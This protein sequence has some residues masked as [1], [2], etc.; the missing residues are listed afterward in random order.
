MKNG[1]SR[2]AMSGPKP[3]LGKSFF[4]CCGDAGGRIHRSHFLLR[5]C[6]LV[7]RRKATDEETPSNNAV[8]SAQVDRENGKVLRPQERFRPRRVSRMFER[9]DQNGKVIGGQRRR[10]E[11]WQ[12]LGWWHGN[13][14][15][16]H[17]E[18]RRAGGWRAVGTQ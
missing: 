3:P 16:H 11:A 14:R 18:R 13:S 12:R 4:S 15:R 2:L 8:I 5:G 10:R 6:G 17:R 1:W 9:T 7:S